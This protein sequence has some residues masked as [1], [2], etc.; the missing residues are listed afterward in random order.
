M[1]GWGHSS[2]SEDDPRVTEVAASCSSTNCRK[3]WNVIRG[4]MSLVRRAVNPPWMITNATTSNIFAGSMLKAPG[5]TGL[6][7]VTARQDPSFETN[8]SLDIAYI[9]TG[10]CGWTARFCSKRFP[11]LSAGPAVEFRCWAGFFGRL[12]HGQNSIR[13]T[14]IALFSSGKCYGRIGSHG[15]SCAKR[16]LV[17]GFD[18]TTRNHTQGCFLVDQG[19]VSAGNFITTILLAR[20]LTPSEYGIYALLFALMLFAVTMHSAAIVYGLSL[21]GAAG[22][23]IQALVAASAS[24]TW[25]GWEPFLGTR[26]D[27]RGL[28]S[29]GPPASPWIFLALLLWQVQETTR[30]GLMSTLRHGDAVWGD[31]LSGIWARRPCSVTPLLGTG[32]RSLSHSNRWRA[33]LSW[34]RLF[35]LFSS[36][37]AWATSG[38]LEPGAEVLACGTMGATRR[39]RSKSSSVKRYSGSWAFRQIADAAFSM[40]VNPG[41]GYGPLG[42]VRGGQRSFC[43]Q[44]PPG[45]ASR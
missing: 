11:L 24:F 21:Y 27:C 34:P 31:A 13:A 3:L 39:T 1:D 32:S 15:V 4:D 44:L 17:T 20:A 6:W 12:T 19:C 7:Q 9:E 8:L 42:D 28:L 45:E 23:R 25:W 14:L 37:F 18:W 10:A 43:R 5:V 40:I 22:E 35:K 41:A 38:G 30:R 29:G 33:L 36:E 26:S 2:I 16:G